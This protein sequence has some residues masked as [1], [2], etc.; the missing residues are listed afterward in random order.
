[1]NVVDSCGWLEY[2]ADGQNADFFAPVIEDTASLIVPANNN[3]GRVRQKAV[4]RQSGNEVIMVGYA[5]KPL[6]HPTKSRRHSRCA[7]H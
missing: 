7:A 4:T 3:V 6:T 2:F 5:M 1:M